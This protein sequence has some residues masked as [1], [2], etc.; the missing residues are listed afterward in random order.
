MWAQEEPKNMGAYT[1]VQPKLKSAV[2]SVR[3]KN[4]EIVNKFVI[5]NVK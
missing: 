2:E 3:G 1:F 4:T 5:L